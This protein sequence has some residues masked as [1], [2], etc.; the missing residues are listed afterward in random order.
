MKKKIFILCRDCEMSVNLNTHPP[1][2]ISAIKN[3]LS[4]GKESTELVYSAVYSEYW[5]HCMQ[6]GIHTPKKKSKTK[7]KSKQAL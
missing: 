6:P 3:R 5:I 4:I 2:F 1:F 7:K